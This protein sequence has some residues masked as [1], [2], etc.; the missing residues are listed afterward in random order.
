MLTIE[1]VKQVSFRRAGIGGYKPEDV[2]AFIDQ[3]LI[4]MEQL[5]KEKSDLV[6]KMDILATRV[7]EYRADEDAVRNAMLASQRVADSTIKSAKAKAAQIIEESENAAKAKLYDLNLQ[8]KE[9]KKQYAL[10]LSEC[11]KLREELI[12]VCNKHI[13]SAKELPSKTKVEIIE[14]QIE[15]RFPTDNSDEVERADEVM[16][17][18]QSVEP[19]NLEAESDNAVIAEEIKIKPV[20]EEIK[21]DN[22]LVEENNETPAVS[23]FFNTEVNLIDDINTAP[24]E[25]DVQVAEKKKKG[26]IFGVLKFGDD[27][28]IEDDNDK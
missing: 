23:E 12:S 28:N 3:V 24:E 7:E 27:Y 25:S 20:V 4:T 15:E 13:I 8:I 9:Q 18:P 14:K 5:K 26:K 10:L 19:V 16:R 17:A 22:A 2:D 11:N 6:K 21:E 1:D